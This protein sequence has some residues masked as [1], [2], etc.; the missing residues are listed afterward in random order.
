MRSS[1]RLPG[2][3]TV[4]LNSA[5]G[6]AQVTVSDTGIGIAAADLPLI[7]DRFYRADK[8][9]SRESGGAGI[10]LSIGRWIA[11]AHLGTVDVT[12]CVAEGTTFSVILPQVGSP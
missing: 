10:G 8:T 1:T 3:V 4:K 11:E 6:I 7:F 5:V 9:R 12:S 2:S